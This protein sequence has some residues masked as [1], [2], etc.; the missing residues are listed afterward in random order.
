M[1]GRTSGA[2][3]WYALLQELVPEAYYLPDMLCNRNG[4]NLGV[5]QDGSRV[6][7]VELPPWAHGS[8]Q[9]FI[10]VQA[11]S[12]LPRGT[13]LAFDMRKACCHGAQPWLLICYLLLTAD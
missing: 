7:D 5:R 2:V 6:E 9:E 11:Q 8:P 10:R 12:M 1:P 13:T 4:F 3:L